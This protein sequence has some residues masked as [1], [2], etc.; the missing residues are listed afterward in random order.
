MPDTPKMV[1]GGDSRGGETVKAGYPMTAQT[2]SVLSALLLSNLM[3]LPPA[4]HHCSPYCLKQ[5]YA[6]PPQLH[7]TSSGGFENLN[8]RSHRLVANLLKAPQY[9]ENTEGPHHTYMPIISLTSLPPLPSLFPTPTHPTK[10]HHS[11]VGV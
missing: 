9:S 10:P 4:L 5:S 3:P 8:T 6:P 7:N 1:P 11:S 2:L